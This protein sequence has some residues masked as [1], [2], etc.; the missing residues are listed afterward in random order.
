MLENQVLINEYNAKL[1]GF[2][3][4]SLCSW[5]IS[6]IFRNTN[7]SFDNQF[8]GYCKNC[9]GKNS[10]ILKFLLNIMKSVMAKVGSIPGCTRRLS[11]SSPNMILDV[12]CFRVA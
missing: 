5:Q 10:Y 7:L 6:R 4:A 1:F 3:R 9:N 8:F 2:Y 11:T 12:A